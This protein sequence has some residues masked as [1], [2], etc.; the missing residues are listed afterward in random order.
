M[1]KLTFFCC[2]DV[3]VWLHTAQ[4]RQGLRLQGMQHLSC[5]ELRQN[6]A[7]N[8]PFRG[9]I[10]LIVASGGLGRQAL[11]D[12]EV[13]IRRKGCRLLEGQHCE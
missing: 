11:S 8:L 13:M 2:R 9:P 4:A 5:S 12:L 7:A 6:H 3:V 1:N 10:G